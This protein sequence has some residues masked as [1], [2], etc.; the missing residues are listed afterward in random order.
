MQRW[1]CLILLGIGW[2]F[3]FL[4]ASALVLEC[5]RPEE[6]TRAQSVPDIGRCYQAYLPLMRAFK[7]VIFLGLTGDCADDRRCIFPFGLF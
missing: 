1:C 4:G 7:V 5:H 6:R 2:N 3:G